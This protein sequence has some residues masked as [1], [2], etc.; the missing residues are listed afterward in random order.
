MG[1]R[2]TVIKTYKVELGGTQGF[3]YDPDTLENIIFDYCDNCFT[4]E[5]DTNTIWSIDRQEFEDMIKQIEELDEEGFNKQMDECWFGGDRLCDELYTKEY[6]L[7]VFKGYLNETPET[8]N[9]VRLMW[10]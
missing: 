4:N 3:N 9:Y 1:L 8:E 2:A 6:V 7:K 5:G 10:V